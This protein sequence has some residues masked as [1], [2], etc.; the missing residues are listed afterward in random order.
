[1]NCVE[2]PTQQKRAD[3]YRKR[4]HVMHE[5]RAIHRLS[6]LIG[7]GNGV[8]SECANRLNG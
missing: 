5:M 6:N 3:D 1:M 4:Q 7:R 8:V 2:Q